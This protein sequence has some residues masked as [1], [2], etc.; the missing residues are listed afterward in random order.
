MSIPLITTKFYLPTSHLRLV[1]RQRLTKRLE[2]GLT[3]PLTLI[4][5]P[6]GYG[7]TTL[8]SEWRLGG[9]KGVPVAWLSLDTDDNDLTRFLQYLTAALDVLQPG[10]AEEAW[11]L[12]QTSEM[13]NMEAVLTFLINRLGDLKQESVL[14]LDDYHL[15]ETT[16]IHR[17]LVF[18]IDH[19]PP[20][21]H[22]V[23]LTRADPAFPLSRLRTRNQMAEIRAEQLRFSIDE[24]AEFLN[25]VMGLDISSSDVAL[26]EARTEGWIAGLQLAALSMQ[27]REDNAGFVKAFTG[28]QHYIVDYLA[29]EVLSRQPEL[30][31]DF[32]IN[33]SILE[34]LNGPL[35]D[36]VVETVNSQH[37]LEQLDHGNVF[38]VPLDDEQRWYRYHHLFADLLHYHLSHSDPDVIAQMHARAAE[39]FE[40]NDL[41]D[42]AITHA[43]AAKDFNRAIRLFSRNQLEIIYT[44]NLSTLDRWLEAFPETLL[45][46]NPWLCIAK[47]N[48]LWSTGRRSSIMPYLLG[49]EKG[50][51]EWSN[52]GQI[53]P[54]D[55]GYRII[56]GYVYTFQS[57]MAMSR[58]DLELAVTLA[59]K[60][61][62]VIPKSARSHAFALG[63]L[64]VAYQLSGEIDKGI[65]TCLETIATAKALNYPSMLTTA[66]Y[67][68][69]LLLRVKGQLHQAADMLK[70][71]LE[72]A[73]RQRQ[74]HVFY[75]GIVHI[76]LAETLYEWNALEEMESALNA[77]L[78]LCWRGGMNILVIEGL[79]CRV[80]LRYAQGDIHGALEIIDELEQECKNMDPRTYQEDC[81]SLRSRLRSELGDYSG[82]EEW[83]KGIDLKGKGGL[84]TNRF[85][86]LYR[87]AWSLIALGRLDEAVEILSSLEASA[88][89]AGH[90]G[91]LIYALALLAL[92]RKARQE[93][94]Q[95]L[96]NLREALTLA[97]AECYV[98]IFLNLGEPIVE[99]LQEAR[100]HGFMPEFIGR[101]L[102]AHEI[103]STA[104][105]S[106]L[107]VPAIL[108]NREL[109]LLRLIAAG[110]SNKQIAG[111][112]FIS[113]GTVKRHTANIFDKL[114]VKNRTEAVARAR[115]LNILS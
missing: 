39:W 96:L 84:G 8:M 31:R 47:A 59:Q 93:K 107:A 86:K 52:C 98:T 110:H 12:L 42:E 73:Q 11:P 114:D 46:A 5:A 18:L 44:R 3:R 76:A 108:S 113:V 28:S 97:E 40:Q 26:L 25:Q 72:Y 112:L 55:D 103:Q 106:R 71:C 100:A 63:S 99:M 60:A 50:L 51:E 61:E 53:S 80:S 14:A 20:R 21:L 2:E 66:T 30:V 27:N 79:F 64:Y 69:A 105:T 45:L 68:L 56:Q 87:A 33:T 67:S 24:A 35:C 70:E 29:E 17:A 10:L 1:P 34:R 15:I 41:V 62:G 4:S 54:T 75:Y 111:E 37:I 89:E 77:G 81:T 78:E 92:C 91:W 109:E 101:I 7:K 88:R 85:G 43:L 65:D 16:S 94:H 74:M 57:L 90:T 32:L 49:A 36:A 13:P 19:M 23:I 9:G 102:T 83:L 6:A 48:I 58:N 38:I 104:R 82:L 95:A 22:L 115:E